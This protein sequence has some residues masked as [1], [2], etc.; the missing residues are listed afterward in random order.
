MRATRAAFV[1]ALGIALGGLLLGTPSN[2][3]SGGTPQLGGIAAEAVTPAVSPVV[4]SGPRNIITRVQDTYVSSTDP[5]DHSAGQILHVG[6]PDSGAT[7]YRTY[8]QFNVEKLKGADIKS[9]HLRLYNSFTGSCDGWWMYAEPAA[10]AWNQSTIDWASQPGVT[11]GYQAAANFGVGHP[12]CPDQPNRTDPD[13]SNGLQ[14]I[15]VTAMVRAWAEKKI[16][17]YGMRLSAG[18]AES[19]AYKD[20]CSMNPA[21]SE[22]ACNIAYNTPTLEVEF[23][24]GNPVVAAGDSYKLPYSGNYPSASGAV[25]FFDAKDP[26]L[27]GQAGPYQRWIPDAYHSVFASNLF[28][29]DWSGGTDFKLRPSGAY[30]SPGGRSQRMLVV[31]DG[32]SGFVGVVPY[33]ALSGYAFA[34]NVGGTD[35]ANLH[36]VELLPDGSVAV[37]LSRGRVEVYTRGQGAPGSPASAWAT[38]ASVQ[39]LPGAHSI[40]WDA[41]DPAHP[42]L[43]AIGDTEIVRYAYLG[44]GKI[45]QAGTGDRFPLPKKGAN[46]PYGHDIEPVHGNPDRFWVSANAGAVQFSKSGAGSCFTG[47]SNWPKSS[48]NPDPTHWCT[49]YSNEKSI[50]AYGMIKSMGND[51]VSGRVVQSCAEVCKRPATGAPL[52][53]TPYVHFFN[54]SGSGLAASWSPQAQHYRSRYLVPS[55]D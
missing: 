20:F 46:L 40:L 53:T 19:K 42:Y 21:A 51:P 44:S 17:N 28:A 49:D 23:N 54:A 5:R 37:A 2:A 10:A 39:S 18:E 8:L 32:G 50:N 29:G 47:S 9:A 26:S 38:P 6:T 24:P 43:W 15:D 48:D 3:H 45:A 27:W 14:R 16:P 34:V 7:K 4:Q 36:G 35:T 12:S 25:E 41:S 30:A 33:P 55:Y 52:W 13:R 22:V 11:S 1:G 31:G